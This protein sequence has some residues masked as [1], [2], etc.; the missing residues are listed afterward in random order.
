MLSV[1][2]HLFWH[3]YHPFWLVLIFEYLLYFIL[4]PFLFTKFWFN[5]CSSFVSQNILRKTIPCTL[6]LSYFVNV[7]ALCV[8]WGVKSAA[9][10]GGGLELHTLVTFFGSWVIFYRT[11]QSKG[12]NIGSHQ[13]SKKHGPNYLACCI[14]KG[15]P[16]KKKNY[17]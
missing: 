1:F 5:F 12:Q 2:Y 16:T 13:I 4:F 3:I 8:D 7:S 10:G 11:T 14:H 9:M 6:T 17:L 15:L